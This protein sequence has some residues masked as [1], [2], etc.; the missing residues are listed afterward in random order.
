MK[1]KSRSGRA[2]LRLK[3]AT[4]PRLSTYRRSIAAGM[5]LVCVAYGG[6][7]LPVATTTSGEIELRLLET[8]DLELDPA[9]HP[10]QRVP[11]RSAVG[12]P[13]GTK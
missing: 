9:P 12:L 8:D 4:A 11:R 13:D 5:G 7:K 10:G 6:C 1:R 2:P 3:G